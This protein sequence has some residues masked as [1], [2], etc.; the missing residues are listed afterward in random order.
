M[1]LG[2][3]WIETHV[4]NFKM[5]VTRSGLDKDSSAVVKYFQDSLTILLQKRIMSLK[6]PPTTLD[7]W[8]KWP[9]KI[10]NNYKK[11]Q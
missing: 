9:M 3:G 1:K 10:D 5:A 6:N 8:C 2:D 7:K 11:M 4:A